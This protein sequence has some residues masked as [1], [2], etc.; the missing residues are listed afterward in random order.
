MNG[1]TRQPFPA[2]PQTPANTLQLEDIHLPQQPGF[3]PPAPGWWLLLALLLGLALLAARKVRSM[4]QQR[5]Q[6]RAVE[7]TLQ[8]LRRELDSGNPQQAITD[9]NVFLRKMALTHYPG[10]D[11]A[12]LTGRQWLE[13]LDRSGHTTEFT[14]GAGAIL[15][16]GPYR[17]EP[18][19]TLDKAALIKAVEQWIK[20]AAKARP[21]TTPLY[22]AERHQTAR[23]AA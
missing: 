11:I 16:E 21:E 18:P 10:E 7:A 13:F 2:V 3:W 12:S 20:R 9:I 23:G 5:K 8:R 1:A 4:L 6:Q 14:R 22:P 15:A 19:A 17:A